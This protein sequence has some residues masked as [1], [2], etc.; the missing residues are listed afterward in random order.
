MSLLFL[1]TTGALGQGVDC[2][3]VKQGKFLHNSKAVGLTLITRTGDIQREE[4]DSLGIIV[5]YKIV[6][7]DSCS[8][9]VTPYKLI[10]NDHNLDLMT[11]LKLVIEILEVKSESYLQRTSSRVTGLSKTSEI[12]ILKN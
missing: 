7:R 1:T 8:Y 10:R 2:Q 6:W 11:D 9:K 4:S 5:E 3:R 12:L